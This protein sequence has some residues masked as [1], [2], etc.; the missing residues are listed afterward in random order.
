MTCGLRTEVQGTRNKVPLNWH[1]KGAPRDHCRFDDSQSSSPKQR[2]GS[3]A[4]MPLRQ[5][6]HWKPRMALGP[7]SF[8]G[9]RDLEWARTS[10]LDG[11]DHRV[12][13][14]DPG[15][16]EKAG[17]ITVSYWPSPD[18]RSIAWVN[19]SADFSQ[20]VITYDLE[21]RKQ[22]QV[23]FGRSAKVRMK[24]ALYDGENNASNRDRALGVNECP[25]TER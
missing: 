7:D 19:P 18:G 4:R 21:N 20:D 1:P 3:L 11:S 13:F 16:S 15:C 12:E 25:S 6:S 23:T 14:V 24:G 5:L 17:L 8:S 2:S 10:K 22:T 9:C